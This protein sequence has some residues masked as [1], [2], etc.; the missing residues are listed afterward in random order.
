MLTFT[1]SGGYSLR[2]VGGN[3]PFVVFPDAKASGDDLLLLPSPEE[4]P[5]SSS[6]SWPGEYDVADITVRG[7]GHEEGQKVSYMV[8]VEGIRCAFPCAP[9]TEWS[10]M[11]IEHLG[12]IHILAIPGNDDLKKAQKLIDDIDP[13]ILF[14]VPG[15]DGA[16]HAELLKAYGAVGKEA[17]KEFKVKGGLMS[18]GR[19]V[20]VFG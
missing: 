16:I 17:V 14:L 20:V 2:C 11:D 4:T 15:K 18:E 10:D 5:P 7:I 3:K 8:E 1:Y 9:L 12:D 13:R 19:E 6:I